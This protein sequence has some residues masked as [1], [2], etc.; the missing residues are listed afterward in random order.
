MPENKHCAEDIAAIRKEAIELLRVDY[1]RVKTGMLRL[2]VFMRTRSKKAVY[3]LRD[4][5]DHLARLFCEDITLEDAQKHLHE[6]RTHLRRCSVEPLEYM[7]EKRFVK[8]DRYVRWLAPI[9]FVFRNS[10]LTKPEFFQKMKEAKQ[11]IVTGRAVK[12]EG[13]AC[14][15]MDKAFE[16]VTDLLAQVGPIQ[17]ILRG[18]VWF[19]CIFVAA[20]LAG[21]LVHYL[22]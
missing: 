12:T 20:F 11:H 6:C 3:E 7:A 15:H 14:E 17:Y 5:L 21:T 13:E 2:E 9:S 4:F 10:P 8:L 19:I 1:P 22:H 16:I 18:V